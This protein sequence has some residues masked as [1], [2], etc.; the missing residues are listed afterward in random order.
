MYKLEKLKK[1]YKLLG[2]NTDVLDGYKHKIFAFPIYLTLMTS[3]AAILMLNI[4]YNKS[5]IYHLSLGIL[6][7][8]II[9]Y[10]NY[11]F[12]V[13]IETQNVP[14]LIWYGAPTNICNDNFN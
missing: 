10:I 7:S 3:I 14:Y 11:F 12:S 5:K 13:V 8:V 1:D 9:Y 4:K 6:L 2:Y